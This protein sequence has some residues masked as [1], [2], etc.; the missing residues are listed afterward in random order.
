[1]TTYASIATIGD[2]ITLG[3]GAHPHPPTLL[4]WF[5]PQLTWWWQFWQ[6]GTPTSAWNYSFASGGSTSLLLTGQAARLVANGANLVLFQYT[7]DNEYLQSVPLATFTT[8][9]ATLRGIISAGLPSARI[10][11][12]SPPA[13]GPVYSAVT[14]SLGLLPADYVTAAVTQATANS[15]EY[16]DLKSGYDAKAAAD[17]VTIDSTLNPGDHIHPEE[18]GQRYMRDLW[19]THLSMPLA[20]APAFWVSSTGAL[21]PSPP[22]IPGVGTPTIAFP[23]T[24]T[25]PYTSPVGN[26]G[27]PVQYYVATANPGGQTGTKSGAGSSSAVVPGIGAVN[28]TFTVSAYNVVGPSLP[29]AVSTPVHWSALTNYLS[30]VVVEKMATQLRNDVTASG[31][32]IFLS[33]TDTFTAD[34]IAFQWPLSHLP[35]TNAPVQPSLLVAGAARTIAQGGSGAASSSFTFLQISPG[36]AVLATGTDGLPPAGT[37]LTLTYQW[38]LEALARLRDET[39]IAAAVALPNQGVIS[40]VI[41]SG[42]Q[43]GLAGAL[44]VCRSQLTGYS[45]PITLVTATVGQEYRGP[46]PQK[47]EV[48]TFTSNRLSVTGD[49]VIASCAMIGSTAGVGRTFRLQLQG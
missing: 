33:Q 29:S 19:A 38:E 5:T 10:I 46:P 35:S 26:G 45:Q 22:N 13:M 1:M 43:T 40:Y 37:I 17:G 30:D 4:P 34:G 12:W 49:F 14:N 16:Y 42:V 6:R 7:V 21:A 44:D 32:T 39:S 8:N 41:G 28:T 24:A 3:F 31:G 15:W 48:L 25:V 9:V 27:K 11:M 47:G 23:G 2:S 20:T 36:Y 18:R